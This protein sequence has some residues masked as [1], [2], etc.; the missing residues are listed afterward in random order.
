MSQD[1]LER[2]SWNAAEVGSIPDFY[3]LRFFKV[4]RSFIWNK[5]RGQTMVVEVQTGNE[6]SRV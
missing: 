4:E 6:S 5:A 1:E 2:L 3:Y